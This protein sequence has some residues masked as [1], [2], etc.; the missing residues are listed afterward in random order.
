MTASLL[1]IHPL[2]LEKIILKLIGYPYWK[3]KPNGY[4]EVAQ[5]EKDD[6]NVGDDVF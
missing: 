5:D 6:S 1:H 2:P 3:T 4:V